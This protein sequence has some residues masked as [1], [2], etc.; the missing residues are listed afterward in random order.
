MNWF[1]IF[2]RQARLHLIVVACCLLSLVT[3]CA[4][5]DKVAP[6][7]Q[8]AT[9][10]TQKA[11]RALWV[12]DAGVITQSEARA[13][14]FEFCRAQNISILYVHLGDFLSDK[15]RESNDVKHVQEKSLGDFLEMAHAKKLRVEA[16]D[17]DPSFARAMRHEAALR[18][19]QLALDYNRAAPAARRLDGF[20]WDIEPYV[21]KEFRDE[22]Q[23]AAVLGEFLDIVR[24]SRDLVLAE[25]ENGEF[26]LGFALPFWM[27]GEKQTVAW[28]GANKPATFQALDTLETLPRA[29]VALMAYRDKAD[30]D[31]GSIAVVRDEINYA[32]QH[33]P[34]VKIVVGQETGAVKG[35]PPSITFYEEGEGALETA[36]AQINAAYAASPVY[37]GVAIHHLGSYRDLIA[38]LPKSAAKAAGEVSLQ[39]LSP[40]DGAEAAAK[41]EVFGKASGGVAVQVSVMPEGDIWYDGAPFAFGENGDWSTPVRIGNDKTAADKRFRIRVRL[42][43]EAGKPLLE[44]QIGVTRKFGAGV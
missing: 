25:K 41:T 28:N 3:A 22:T 18:R 35:D 6:N 15:K 11:P 13:E 16:L 27:D 12:W 33:T 8:A 23:H 38:R 32:T 29:Y 26:W 43:D 5:A 40:R 20:Q 36:L 39:I 42:L 17:G 34:G 14:L 31:N 19:L 10:S 37:G 9:T 4:H 21:L 24:K 30:G 2:A 1:S 44:K 7:S